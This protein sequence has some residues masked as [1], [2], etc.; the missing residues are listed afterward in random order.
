MIELRPSLGPVRGAEEASKTAVPGPPILAP[1]VSPSIL[2]CTE[3]CSW[4]VVEGD[5]QALLAGRCISTAIMEAEG[6]LL[7]S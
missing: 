5:P 2:Q 4:W 3:L 6:K 7:K 1:G